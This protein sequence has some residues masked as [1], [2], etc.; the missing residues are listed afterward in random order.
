M[1]RRRGKSYLST[2]R[3]KMS[4]P[5]QAEETVPEGGGRGGGAAV[6]VGWGEG[7][8]DAQQLGGLPSLDKQMT[9]N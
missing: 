4:P 1:A 8:E 2:R 3:Q 7:R 6:V 5:Y 9:D